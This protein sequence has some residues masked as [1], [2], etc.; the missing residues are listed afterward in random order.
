MAT[1]KKTHSLEEA[2]RFSVAAGSA[3]AFSL[4]LCTSEKVEESTT[5]S[6]IGEIDIKKENDWMRIT[7][8]LTK[9][10]INLSLKSTHKTDAIEELVTVLDSAGKLAMAQSLKK[11]FLKRRTKYN[12]DW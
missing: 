2:F 11:P 8:L 3:T 6:K 12:G 5:P 10:T 1:L 7:E 4:G 9:E